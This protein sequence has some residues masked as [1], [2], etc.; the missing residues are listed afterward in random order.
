MFNRHDIS[1]NECQLEGALASLGFDW[2]WHSFSA[3]DAETGE[4]KSFFIGFY[5]CNPALGRE[6]PVLGQTKANKR[7][8]TKPSYLMIKAGT[9]G[10]DAAQVHRFFGCKKV[11][12]CY[13]R[14]FQISA[15]DCFL[16]EDATHGSVKVSKEDAGYYKEWMSQPGEMSWSLV[17]DKQLAFNIGPGSGKLMRKLQAYQGFWHVEGMRTAYS[18]EV[19]WNGRRYIVTPED[20][21]GYAD[22][23][24][25]REFTSPLIR[26][27]SS[28]LRSEITG[29]KL[30]DTAFVMLGGTPKMGRIQLKRKL[31]TAFWYEGKEYEFNA[32]RFLHFCRAKANC[33]ENRGRVIWRI[34]QRSLKDRIVAN[35]VCDKKDMLLVNFESPDG[36]RLHNRLWN[37]GNGRGTI[38]L[39]RFGRLVDRMHVENLRCDWG[40]YR[41]NH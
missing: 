34:E 33:R 14:P 27:S 38:E 21:Y 3:K 28:D 30:E 2:W 18:G 25:G 36:A 4:H 1:I 12:M 11:D 20:S 6:K 23:N 5:L 40:E 16:T 22:K 31:L 9:W 13:T 26:L 35:M 15:G 17:M 7:S 39:Y 19:T 41:K 8:N 32:A 29:R 24:W 10:A 37:G